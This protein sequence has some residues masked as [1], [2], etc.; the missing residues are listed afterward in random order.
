MLSITP[1]IAGTIITVGKP[2][3]SAKKNMTPLKIFGFATPFTTV[4]LGIDSNPEKKN[5]GK[6]IKIILIDDSQITGMLSDTKENSREMQKKAAVIGLGSSF[7]S[8]ASGFSDFV[9]ESKS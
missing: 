4:T 6:K 9:R 2:L 3:R 1:K 8:L 7:Q 5:P